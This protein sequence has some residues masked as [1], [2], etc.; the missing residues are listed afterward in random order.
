[1]EE[2]AVVTV[3]IAADRLSSQFIMK[4]FRQDVLYGKILLVGHGTGCRKFSLKVLSE[5]Q[6]LGSAADLL[7]N[8]LTRS[9]PA[10]TVSAV[11]RVDS[12]RSR[13]RLQ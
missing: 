8:S 11:D 10:F 7:Q 2:D 3:W 1:M 5:L 4:P 13:E 6:N 12:L 9:T